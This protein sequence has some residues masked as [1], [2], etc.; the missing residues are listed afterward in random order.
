M[1]INLAWGSAM[2]RMLVGNDNWGS[3]AMREIILDEMNRLNRFY[4][5]ELDRLCFTTGSTPI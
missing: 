5:R 1:E 3:T 4:N 2:K